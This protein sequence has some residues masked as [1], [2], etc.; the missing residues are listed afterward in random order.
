MLRH[1]PADRR[2]PRRRHR[3]Q[4][5]RARA[6]RAHGGRRGARRRRR[7]ARPLVVAGRASARRCRRASSASPGITQAMVDR[8]PPPEAVLPELAARMRGRVLVAH[9][10]RFDARVLRGAFSRAAL[11][12]PDPP[13]LCTVAMA[14]RLAPLQQPPRARDAGRRAGD[15]GGDDAPRAAGRRA[16]RAGLLRAVQAPVRE[17][18]DGGGGGGAAARQA[19]ASRARATPPKVRMP[20]ERR[21]DLRALTTGP[22]V[23]VFRDARR[24]AAVRRQVGQRAHARAVALHRRRGVDGAGRARRLRG[25]GVRARRAAARAPADPRAQAARQRQA[26]CASR[27]GR[28]S[29]AA[30]ST[31]RSR[32]SRSRASRRP[33]TRSASARCAAAPRRPSSSSSSTRCS[34]CAT[35]AASCRAAT[36]RPPTGRW[37]AA[38]R[39]AWA[40]WT[41]TSTAS[42]WRRRCGCSSTRA[43][44]AAPCSSTSRRRCARRRRRGSTSARRRCSAAATGWTRCSSASA[45]CCGRCTRARGWSSRRIPKEPGRGD[46]IL[47]VGRPRRRLASAAGRGP[48]GALRG[49]GRARA[50]RPRDLGGWL[51][52]EELDEVRL[53]GAPT[54]R[55]CDV[56]VLELPAPD[57]ARL[58]AR[59]RRTAARPRSR[60]V[61]LPSP[62]ATSRRTKRERDRAEGGGDDARP[63]DGDDLAVAAQLGPGGQRRVRA[64]PEQP[65]VGLAPV[66][67]PRD[68]LLADVAAL[69]E[70][71]GAL[72]EP[73]LLGDDAVVEVDAVARPAATPRARSRRPPRVP[74]GS[75]ERRLDRLHVLGVA[76]DVGPEVGR[77][78]RAPPS[79]RRCVCSGPSTR[80]SP[81]SDEQPAL[82]PSA[83]G[84]RRRGRA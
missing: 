56:A 53:V 66:E 38:C 24:A 62:T 36:T 1:P 76:D 4:R 74:S 28:S 79:S 15:R 31:S 82:R 49:G 58:G 27:T 30:A 77:D 69:L 16:V 21:P 63:D 32:S 61:E 68:G 25:D 72:V 40:T 26:A 71:H 47:L 7:A 70:V 35:A 81:I 42:G 64:Q 2:V 50:P 3:D 80:C 45:A 75:A 60:A 17:R 10:A 55:G 52:A 6:L 19:A 23:Y 11:D 9:N 14:R 33:A 57:P 18:R 5:A 34:A 59:R 22:G 41:R 37:A 67:E 73:R 48:R 65:A 12:W 39:R 78:Q 46:A 51:P 8:A 84:S 83:C 29:S 13:V 43:T 20:V 54:W 44:A